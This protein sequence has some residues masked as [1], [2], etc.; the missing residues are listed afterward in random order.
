[1]RSTPLSSAPTS[2]P[3]NVAAQGTVVASMTLISRITGFARDVVLSHFFGATPI[4]DAFFVALRIPNF[5]RRLFAEGAFNQAFVP[6]LVRYR[7]QG[8]APLYRFVSAMSGNLAAAVTIVVIL[9]VIFAPW[10]TLVFAPGFHGTERFDLTADMLRITFPYLA[11]VS[12]VAFFG[13]ILNAHHQY[14]VPAI[15]PVLLNIVLLVAASLGWMHSQQPVFVLAWGVF[16]AGL[17]QWLFQIPSLHRIGLLVL[18]EVNLKHEGAK[19]VGRLLVPAVLASSV[20][21]IN[22]LIDTVLASTLIEGS[23]SWLYY[24]DRLLELPIGLVAVA[25]GTVLLPN[26]SRLD[27]NEDHAGFS[28]TLDWG[29]SLALMLGIPAGTALYLLADALIA[30]IYFHGELSAYDVKMAALSLRAFAAAV[31]PLVMVK[32]LAPAYFARED[33]TTPFR[34]GLVAI[35]AN[36]VF[37]LSVFSW[38][39]HVGLAMGTAVSSCI[40]AYLLTRGLFARGLYQPGRRCKIALLRALAGALVMAACILTFVPTAEAW[41]VVET[42]QRVIWLAATVAGAGGLYLLTL[43]VLGVRPRHLRHSV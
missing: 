36:I 6:V 29:M 1:M 33:T 24:S 8:G 27:A 32:I 39:G 30:T 34:I 31:L 42:W 18:P 11:F 14:A 15:T 40:N 43:F 19:Q 3:Q 25:L 37:N 7:E 10:V 41:L 21:Q 38:F 20:S 9:G 28:A 2:E 17:V 26:L 13:A 22:T 5:F 23:V 16:V 35:G 12:M 4:A